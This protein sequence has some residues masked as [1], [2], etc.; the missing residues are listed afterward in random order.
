MGSSPDQPTPLPAPPPAPRMIDR[1]VLDARK[2][3][4]AKLRARSGFRAT[5]LTSATGAQQGQRSSP[6]S[7]LGG[8]KMLL[9]G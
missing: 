5:I 8:G 2:R 7:L 4:R 1:A 3:A 6:Q 9:G